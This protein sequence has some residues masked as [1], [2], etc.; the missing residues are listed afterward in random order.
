MC[1][2][3]VALS[4]ETASGNLIFA[5]NS[6]REPNEA[7]AIVRIPAQTTDNEQVECTFITIPQV[8]STYEV[9]L[10]KPFQM[11]GAEMG[12][13]EKGLIIG[14]E[15]V[16][17]K[18]KFTKKNQGLTGMDLLRLALERTATAE[19]AIELIT[20]LLAEYGQDA[21][22][23]YENRNFYYHN[24]FILADTQSA[25][26]LETAGKE[27]VA[28]KV[29][30]VRSIS[31]GLT[32]ENDYD[33]I[34]PNA[35]TWA[36]KQ[37]WL[38]TG[39][40]FSFRKAYSDSLITYMSSCKIRQSHTQNA[41]KNQKLTVQTAIQILQ[42]HNL[43]ESDF[44]PA[45]ASSASVCMHATSMLNPSQTN[46]SMVVENNVDKPA[47]VWLTGTSMPCLSVFK[48]F[49]LGGESIRTDTFLSPS[50]QMDASLWWQAEKLHR[51]VCRDYQKAKPLIINE[52]NQLQVDFLQQEAIYRAQNTDL[53]RLDLFS[54]ECLMAHLEH[55]KI[56]SKKIQTLPSKLSTWNPFYRR[57][58]KYYDQKAGI[59]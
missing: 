23:G 7:Q 12:I 13:N 2:T 17:T 34:S 55:L 44:S 27:W 46:G 10:S 4:S 39:E 40:D 8:K 35:I 33:L 36:K 6:D 1:D 31:N 54:E 43:P 45:Q 57:W 29:K 52:L 14:N 48:P 18:V 3:F 21:C 24:S 50:A 56:W 25:W 11:W 19:N 38:K 16:F 41:I 53:K 9:I 15:A 32:I 30:N 28:Q 59:I 20:S 47:T 26:V 42:S 5:K 58:V 22:G 49:F 51:L 37:G